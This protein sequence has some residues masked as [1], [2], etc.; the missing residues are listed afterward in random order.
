MCVRRVCIFLHLY[1][2]VKDAVIRTAQ[3]AV[4]S[5]ACVLTTRERSPCGIFPSS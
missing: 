2:R 3:F 1:V 5:T 4:C